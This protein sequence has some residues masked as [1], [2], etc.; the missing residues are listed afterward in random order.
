M[1]FFSRLHADSDRIRQSGARPDPQAN[2][3]YLLEVDN[4][5]VLPVGTKVRFVITSDDVI[6]S[7]WV[8]ALGWKQDAVPGKV[9]EGW[10]LIEKPG[11]YRGQC[12]E[13]CGKD[14]GFMP[15]VVEAL[16]REEFARWLARKKQEL[17][18][19]SAAEESSAVPVPEAGDDDDGA[20]PAGGTGVAEATAS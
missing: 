8:P 5:L 7:W 4:P 12:A 16:P 13:L 3:H 20:A 1:R 18:P 11:I 6:H 15:V 9:N 19:P 10:T 2:P 17:A 14:H